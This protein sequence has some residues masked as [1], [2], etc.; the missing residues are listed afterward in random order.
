[1]LAG[2]QRA[3]R[4]EARHGQ[5]N[6][7]AEAVQNR[8]GRQLV[9]QVEIHLRDA[10]L[11]DP[12][13]DAGLRMQH[14]QEIGLGHLPVDGFAFGAR[15]EGPRFAAEE[16]L[17]PQRVAGGG[18]EDRPRVGAYEGD[19]S[20]MDDVE[21]VA[22]L[23][24]LVEIVILGDLLALHVRGQERPARFVQA[25]KVFPQVFKQFVV[26]HGEGSFCNGA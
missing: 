24:L 7:R 5:Q 20:G 1:M 16:I 22:G 15:G 13:A 10:L 26:V 3:R 14:A 9:A 2:L 12:E 11:F 25:G 17:L 8:H 6:V 19:A 21:G 18:R 23:G 4:E